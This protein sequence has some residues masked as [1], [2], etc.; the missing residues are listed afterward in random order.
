MPLIRGAKP[1]SRGFK[2]N[3]REEV[4]A[5]KPIRQAIAISYSESG[6]KKKAKKKK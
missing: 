4:K 1:G 2:E 6:E 5:G 3:I